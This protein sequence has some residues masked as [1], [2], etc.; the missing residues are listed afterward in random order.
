MSP[1]ASIVIP[2][3]NAGPLFREVLD[4]VYDQEG[5]FEVLVIDSGSTDETLAIAADY[6]ADIIE[7]PPQEFDHGGTR[8]LGARETSGEYI[9]FLTQDATPLP[10]WLANLLAPLRSDATL[11][12]VYSKQVPRPDATPMK[13][14][15]LRQ[16]YHDTPETRSL[17]TGKRPTRDDIF[18]SNVS[19]AI[20][21][22]VWREV[23]MPEQRIMSED[24]QWA[25]EVLTRGYKIRYEP[26]SKVRHS[27]TEGIRDIFK[28]YFDSGAS[29]DTFDLASSEGTFLSDVLSY[30]LSEWCYL[31]HTGNHHWIPYAFVYNGAKFTGL[32]LGRHESRL[33]EWITHRISDTLSRKYGAGG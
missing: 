33:P 7:I 11:A 5:D 27:H 22:S 21:R 9:V 1:E 13:E 19:A 2:T 30:Q 10:G 15:F 14:H 31:V 25:R 3:K 18:F 29:L 12:G 16:F 17:E 28:R 6:P 4:A 24:Q 26:T 8:N 20:R 23:P 32:L